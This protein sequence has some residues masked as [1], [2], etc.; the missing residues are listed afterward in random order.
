MTFDF[1]LYTIPLLTILIVY[2]RNELG[3]LSGLKL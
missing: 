2:F 3:K 1:S